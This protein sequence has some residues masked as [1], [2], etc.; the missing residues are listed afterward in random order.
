MSAL[1]PFVKSIINVTKGYLLYLTCR[2]QHCAFMSIYTKRLHTSHS[3][4]FSQFVKWIPRRWETK[5][6]FILLLD[7]LF[8]REKDCSSLPLF[9]IWKFPSTLAF[10]LFSNLAS[11]RLHFT[12]Q[13]INR[14]FL[15]RV[16]VISCHEVDLIPV[17]RI[18][19][20]IRFYYVL[21]LS[22]TKWLLEFCLA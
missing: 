22:S 7:F 4:R 2:L 1:Q 5:F 6:D 20:V 3:F 21:I 19:L 9:W 11:N 14:E 17:Y 18:N 13:I 10:N 8:S 15:V 12:S 16:E